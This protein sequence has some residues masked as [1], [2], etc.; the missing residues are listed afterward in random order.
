MSEINRLILGDNLEILRKLESESIDLIYLDPPFFSNRNYEVIWGD[1]GEVRSFEDRFSGGIDHY[2]AWLKER[3][4]EMHRI[5]KPT[6]S[7]FLHC[8]WHADAYIR[9]LI[10]DKIFGQ[11]NF[12]GEIAWQRHNAHNDAK[13]KLAVL[14]D[15]IFY[16]TKNGRY[17][18]NPIYIGLSDEYKNNFYRYEDEKGIFRLSD[19]TAPGINKNDKEWK[20]FHPNKSGRHWAIPSETVSKLIPSNK[21]LSSLEKLDL[22]YENNFIQMSKSGI[23]SFKRY[24]DTSKGA[25][26][27]DIWID[28]PAVASQSNEK[29]GYPTQKPEK[30]LERIVKMSSNENDVILD[31]FV[32]G[33]TTVAVADKLNRHWIGIDQ[34]VS[35]IKVTEMRM[36]NQQGLFSKPFITQLHK[37]DYDILRNKDAF[38]FESFIITQFD[39]INN[40]KQRNDLGLDG[41]TR[42]NQ[43]IQ[44]KRSDQIGRNVID[45]FHSAV[46]RNDKNLYEKLKIEAKPIGYIIAF[47]F[48][49]GAI[50]EVARLKNEENVIIKLVTVEEI[51]PIAKKPTLNIQ[52]E[53][54]GNDSKGTREI[55]F[56]A[57]AH[58]ESGV[59]F[60]AW[61]FDYKNDKFN[62]QILIDKSGTQTQK[63]KAG[64][65]NIAVKVV[66]CEGLESLELLR[67]KVNGILERS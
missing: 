10:L 59:E 65:Y 61:D 28:I 7:I 25:L 50:Q 35:A 33:G 5:L 54:K 18:Y 55:D 16:Y 42:D 6:G 43:P 29:I 1:K 57:I 66:D 40:T 36:Q 39:G 37:Y 62:P 30:L 8:D 26:L 60:F 19:L 27:G 4:I 49:K 20:K 46:M 9:V 3:V 44:V 58:S 48:G 13:K 51:V 22:L 52:I 34:S 56:T 32:G 17:T 24:L 23:P 15:S 47:S 12:R 2:I 21:E 14:K 45:N 64:L 38:E 53:D 67:L 11:D 41:K 31:P 63:F